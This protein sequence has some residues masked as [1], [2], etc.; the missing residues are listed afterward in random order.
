MLSTSFV[1]SNV[2]F[3][4]HEGMN[5][6]I[7]NILRTVFAPVLSIKHRWERAR[8]RRL[9]IRNPRKLASIR[10]KNRTGRDLDWNNPQDLDEKVNWL[11][12]N[13]DTSEWTRLSDKYLVRDY[14]IERGHEDLL[15]KLYGVWS[16]ADEIDFDQLPDRFVLKTNHGSGLVMIVK[17]KRQLDIPQTRKTL[18]KWL[19]VPYGIESVEMQYLPIKP[20]LIAE[21]LLEDDNPDS[22]SL[23][24]YKVFCLDGKAY[25]FMICANRVMGVHMEATFYD[26]DWHII[27]NVL[28]SEHKNDHVAVRKPQCLPE[29][30]K[31]A[32]DLANGHPEV[33]VDFYIVGN[34][35]YFGEM[36]FTS[37]GGYSPLTRSFLLEMGAHVTLPGKE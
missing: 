23:V 30:I 7:K 8:I 19:K 26:L 1:G 17:D 29:L 36:T 35:I 13:T 5:E 22:F 32:E 20:R 14:L 33:R 27:P 16:D 24:D 25:C 11:K 10:Y 21:E 4:S 34:K 12:F 9:G 15:V 31:A 2:F 37:W 3:F 6:R 28:T 18:N